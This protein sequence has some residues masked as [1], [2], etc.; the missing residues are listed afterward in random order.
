[1]KIQLGFPRLFPRR[2]SV[3][4]TFLFA[5]IFF[6]SSIS[7]AQAVCTTQA[8]CAVD[9]I[10][11][12]I[13]G[14]VISGASSVASSAS[15][16]FLKPFALGL[17]G[18]EAGLANAAA[19]LFAFMLDPVAFSD[20][21]NNGVFYEIW[22]IVRDTMNMLFILV[23]LFSAFAT[24]YQIDR[25]KY[26][27]ILWMVVL[28]ALLVNFSWPIARTIVDFFNSMMYFFV[29][30]VFQTNGP[31]AANGILGGA[32]LKNIF[33]PNNGAG[34]E[35][36]QIILAVVTMAIFAITLLVLSLMMLIRLVALPVL[37]MFSPLGFAGMAAPFTHSYAK[38]W[39]DK[40]FQYA[41]FGPIA[42]FMVLASIRILGAMG[43]WKLH[44]GVTVQKMSASTGVLSPE[45][46]Q[47]LIFFAI[48]I[49][50]MW[51][52]ITSARSMSNQLSSEATKYGTTFGKWAGR[53]PWRATKGVLRWTGASGGIEEAWKNRR[54][55]FG[56]DSRRATEAR[57]NRLAGLIGGGT[58]G[59]KNAGYE[60]FE[61]RVA[62]E[63]EALKKFGNASKAKGLLNSG[64]AEQK[65]AA[66]LYLA[67]KEMLTNAED[68]QNALRAVG[69]DFSAAR[70]IISKA[71]KSSL[72][73]ANDLSKSLKILNDNGHQRLLGETI[74]KA[75]KGALGTNYTEYGSVLAQLSARDANGN[76][77]K[78]ASG[79][80]I[81]DAELEKAYN[82]R[83][84]AEGQTHI[85]VDTSSWT[86]QTSNAV[87]NAAYG[88]VFDKINTED[89]VKQN[90]DDLLKNP[91]FIAYL[92]SRTDANKE[93]KKQLLASAGRQSDSSVMSAWS[94]GGISNTSSTP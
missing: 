77:R 38:K 83:L 68:L 44:M 90:K 42:V 2:T 34:A 69:T 30:S 32:D 16:S 55:L 82:R 93:Y 4:L 78:D 45:S 61:K 91:N 53:Q 89:L 59:F 60:N 43:D 40:L 1:M 86:P 67:E 49:I 47:T 14:T 3:F 27:K 39:W 37:V 36:P 57:A 26:N 21:M 85:R 7:P 79:K 52:A 8:G 84:T 87:K 15:D 62:A 50:L 22:K 76:I 75:E 9:K 24:I 74:L 92:K 33:L 88:E 73:N 18:F 19:G 29:Q 54:G 46:L 81:V 31:A 66:A 51:M 5:F 70:N 58:S 23:L 56:A 12:G 10:L 28:M 72:T 71:P 41:S 35:W 64:N 13:G 17:L 94:A 11:T 63:Q 25:Y 6:S 20:I 65:K 48:P 80:A